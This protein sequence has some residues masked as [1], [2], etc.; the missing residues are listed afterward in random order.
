LRAAPPPPQAEA[1][2][3]GE[4][5]LAD[6]ARAHQVPVGV[7]E[8]FPGADRLQARRLQR[9]GLPLR[10]SQVG[11]ADHADRAGAPRLA[12]GPLDQVVDI[13]AFLIRQQAGRALRGSGAQVSAA[14]APVSPWNTMLTVIW[15]PGRGHGPRAAPP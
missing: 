12:R 5:G 8:S 9:R 1:P 15:R 3:P 4:P 7:G 2:Q 11:H 6:A 14:W 13:L 10:D